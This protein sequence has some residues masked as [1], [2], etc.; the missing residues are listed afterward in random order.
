MRHGSS[1]RFACHCLDISVATYYS[2]RKLSAEN[3][4]MADWLFRLATTN[5]RRGV[6][7]CYLHVRNVKG[8]G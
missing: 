7:L 8:Y 6:G 3:H 1:I 2:M 5:K 4:R